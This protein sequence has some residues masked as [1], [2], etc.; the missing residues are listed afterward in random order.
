MSQLCWLTLLQGRII[1]IN[2][3]EV[4]IIDPKYYDQLFNG[5]SKKSDKWAWSTILFGTPEATFGTIAH[6]HHRIRRGVL[7]HFFSKR[8]V[9][10][11]GPNK[12]AL[13]DKLCDRLREN[14][15]TEQPMNLFHLYSA[16]TMDVIPTYCFASSSH[17]LDKKDL[18]GYVTVA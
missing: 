6:N 14:Y 12:Q 4:H 13:V 7:S 16:L 9:V 3:Y 2:P 1:C 11:L 5:S 17:C 8:A 15:E 10:R 18:V